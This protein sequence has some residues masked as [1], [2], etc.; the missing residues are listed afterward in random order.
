MTIRLQNPVQELKIR[1]GNIF[2]TELSLVPIAIILSTFVCSTQSQKE[3]E[4]EQE[5][6][7]RSKYPGMKGPG[8]S[9]LLQKR[10][11]QKVV[12]CYWLANVVLFKKHFKLLLHLTVCLFFS[13]T[14]SY[15]IP[16]LLVLLTAPCMS[17][18]W[19]LR[20]EKSANLISDDCCMV[21]ESLN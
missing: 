18:Y 6:Q 14:Y 21:K 13:N 3:I 8:T 12:C 20:K 19:A 10:L 5:A 2:R 16:Q 17:R 11:S 7:L 4:K 15:P 1:I 9:T